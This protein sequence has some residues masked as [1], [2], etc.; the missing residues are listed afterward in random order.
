MAISLV[1]PVALIAPDWM[2]TFKGGS[3][4]EPNL[5]LQLFTL[6]GEPIDSND[7]I[8]DLVGE[9]ACRALQAVI[10]HVYSHSAISQASRRSNRS[11]T[12]AS[13][14]HAGILCK[15]G[16]GTPPWKRCI[17]PPPPIGNR[18]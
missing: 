12:V 8:R 9:G 17:H 15:S 16:P 5:G 6:K 7:G 4:T 14:T 1:A 18:D 2:E 11:K 10:V 13:Y 3:P